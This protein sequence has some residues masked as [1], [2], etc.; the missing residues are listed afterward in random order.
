[1]FVESNDYELW[2]AKGAKGWHW[3]NVLPY[4]KKLEQVSEN[5]D[6]RGNFGPITVTKEIPKYP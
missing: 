1:M 2:S 3:A 4:F 5:C 6:L